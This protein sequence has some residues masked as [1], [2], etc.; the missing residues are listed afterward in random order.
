MERPGPWK[1]WHL[2]VAVLV[3]ALMLGGLVALRREA[4]VSGIGGS[5]VWGV[6]GAFAITCFGSARI[7]TRIARGPLARWKRWGVCRG[8]VIGF[9]AWLFSTLADAAILVG[10][11]AAGLAAAFGLVWLVLVE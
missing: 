5:L 11:V 4:T 2:A 8:G 3:V 7:G 6:I 9:L 1:L 10:A